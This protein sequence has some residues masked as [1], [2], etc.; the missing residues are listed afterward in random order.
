MTINP[1]SHCHSAKQEIHLA[2]SPI[3]SSLEYTLLGTRRR[4]T[5]VYNQIKG[6]NN[7]IANHSI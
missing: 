7:R 3:I 6:T 4:G 5:D 2:Q 1:L